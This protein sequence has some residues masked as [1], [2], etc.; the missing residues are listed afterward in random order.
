[1]ENLQHDQIYDRPGVAVVTMQAWVFSNEITESAIVHMHS[2]RFVRFPRYVSLG[3]NAETTMNNTT[4]PVLFSVNLQG[5]C[6][7]GPSTSV[8]GPIIPH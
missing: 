1:M 7:C 3:Y 5:N 8:F 4:K 2:R 6:K